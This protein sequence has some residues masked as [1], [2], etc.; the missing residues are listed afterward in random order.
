MINRSECTCACHTNPGVMHVAACCRPDPTPSSNDEAARELY[1]SLKSTWV[2]GYDRK[3]EEQDIQRIAAALATLTPLSN[4]SGIKPLVWRD[5]ESLFGDEAPTYSEAVGAG[6]TYVAEEFG[7]D[8]LAE[9][10]AKAEKIY[11]E[12][13]LSALLNPTPLSRTGG[14]DRLKNALEMTGCKDEEDLI[15]MANVGNSLM[16]RI[17]SLVKAPGPYHRWSP[18]DDP[19]EI[20]YDLV[21]D[22]DDANAALVKALAALKHARDQIQHPD[23]LID[24][25]ITAAEALSA[26]AMEGE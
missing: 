16:E 8:T 14:P 3:T 7:G 6:Y 1:V 23:E 13:I 9:A 17:D 25:A 10:K 5:S 11:Q 4:T 24:E 22:L 12:N 26:T 20:V 18:A 15:D 21:N 2:G 19:A